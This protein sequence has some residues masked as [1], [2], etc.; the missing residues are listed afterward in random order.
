MHKAY[1]R[2]GVEI[3]PVIKTYRGY[4]H[5]PSSNDRNCIVTM[6][7]NLAAKTIHLEYGFNCYGNE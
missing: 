3:V 2:Y 6:K 1:N 5:H 4:Q 7:E